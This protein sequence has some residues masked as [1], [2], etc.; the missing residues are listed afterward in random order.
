MERGP[1]KV[2]RIM[3]AI[4][5]S[6]FVCVFAFDSARFTSLPIYTFARIEKAAEGSRLSS[7]EYLHIPRVLP[8]FASNAL[9]CY[10]P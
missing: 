9:Y 2:L 4:V 8:V 3:T 10:P 1:R 6:Y 5:F 7:L